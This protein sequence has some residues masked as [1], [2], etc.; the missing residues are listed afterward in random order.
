MGWFT[1]CG[2]FVGSA[3]SAYL[4]TS[5]KLNQRDLVESK[6]FCP[7]ETKRLISK[8]LEGCRPSNEDLTWLG[9]RKTEYYLGKNDYFGSLLGIDSSTKS[10]KRA[11]CIVALKTAA[12]CICSGYDAEDLRAVTYSYLALR[13]AGFD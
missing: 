4:R 1:S 8:T 5:A 13:Q 11:L 10:T 12:K 7:D 2:E 9:R 6:D 3:T